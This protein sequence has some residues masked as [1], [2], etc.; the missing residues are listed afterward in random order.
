MSQPWDGLNEDQRN[1]VRWV[2]KQPL[3]TLC[4]CGWY[5]KGEC[6]NCDKNKVEELEKP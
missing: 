6:P 5:L 3:K 2:R 1:Y 4:N